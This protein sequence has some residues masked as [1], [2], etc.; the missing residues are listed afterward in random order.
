MANQIDKNSWDRAILHL[1]TNDGEITLAELKH[2]D[3]ATVTGARIVEIFYYVGASG[4]ILIDR[5]GTQAIKLTAGSGGPLIGNI[6]YR[7]AG[8]AL[9]GSDSAD[10]G[11]TVAGTDTLATLVVHK[12]H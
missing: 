6:N 10:I 11:V 12:I 8:V 5:G 3:E 4:S 1:D 9:R 2:A 7:Q